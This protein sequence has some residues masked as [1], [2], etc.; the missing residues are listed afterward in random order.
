MFSTYSTGQKFG[1]T[2]GG[3]IFWDNQL[4]FIRLSIQLNLIVCH[5]NSFQFAIV[6][7]LPRKP[8][9]EMVLLET[10]CSL[11][12]Y[13]WDLCAHD[14]EMQLGIVES[15]KTTNKPT[16]L[17]YINRSTVA[18]FLFKMAPLEKGES[19]WQNKE[20]I[21]FLTLLPKTVYSRV[22]ETSSVNDRK[23]F[24]RW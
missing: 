20:S 6:Y 14:L 12:A 21:L 19:W 16:K 5:D 11:W 7:S 15:A 13:G 8:T 23:R 1:N 10:L 24:E 4:Q 2:I 9:S 17:L 3:K 22:K 18:F